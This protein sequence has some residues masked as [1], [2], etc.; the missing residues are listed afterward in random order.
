MPASALRLVTAEFDT[1]LAAAQTHE[2][3]VAASIR[4]LEGWSASWEPEHDAD[5]HRALC[6][7]PL[8]LEFADLSVILCSPP[9]SECQVRSC[10]T[11]LAEFLLELWPSEH[12]LADGK[13]FIFEGLTNWP[14]R[15]IAAHVAW[16]R[17]PFITLENF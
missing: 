13:V 14:D 2:Q 4:T 9:R 7:M 15:T 11:E 6:M 17:R 3:R 12:V 16:T 1:T 5:F 10:G 8:G